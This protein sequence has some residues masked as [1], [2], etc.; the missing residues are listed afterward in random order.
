MT[1]PKHFD[2]GTPMPITARYTAEHTDHGHTRI[3]SRC[4]AGHGTFSWFIGKPR[5]LEIKD[6]GD[7]LTRPRP[8][9]AAKGLHLDEI[10][11]KRFR[12]G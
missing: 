11:S 1:K 8:R 2:H 9:R 12:R 7:C 10:E 3:C 4:G 5:N 6:C